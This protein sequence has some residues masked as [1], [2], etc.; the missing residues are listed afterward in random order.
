MTFKLRQIALMHGI[1]T[2]Y[3]CG[4][5][6]LK[7]GAGKE[8]MEFLKDIL[9][10]DLYK[11]VSDTV[12]AYNGKPENKDKQVKLA[13]LGSGQYVDKGKYDTAVA[14]K[15]N[16][17]GQIKTLNTTIGDLKKNNADNETLQTTIANLQGELKKQQTAS[18]EIAKTY[19]LKDSLTKQGVLDPDYLIYKAGGLEKFN[20]DKEG[21]PIGVEE[22]VKPYKDDA[23]MAHLFKQ[24]QPKPPYNPKNGGA[25]G[26]TNPFAKDTFNLTEQGRM[27]KEN[28]AQAKELAAAAGV[29][30]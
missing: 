13:D 20:F 21:K 15:E 4:D 6:T 1:K 10:E 18:E 25:G 26:V 7:N 17:A 12:N 5:T 22:V 19:A 29:T 3:C 16:L 8:T 23:A 11:Q 2:A 9:G 24:E 28:P 27:L 14:E 30:L